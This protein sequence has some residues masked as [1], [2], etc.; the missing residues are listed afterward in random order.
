L[1]IFFAAEEKYELKVL[2]VIKGLVWLLL[3][4]MVEVLSIVLLLLVRV[5]TKFHVVKDLLLD[6][7][8]NESRYFFFAVVM[9]EVNILQ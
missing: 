3:T 8:I 1:I 4:F 5:L 7:S 6:F 9:S 2:A